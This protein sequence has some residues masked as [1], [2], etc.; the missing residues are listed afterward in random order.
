MH[1]PR[2]KLLAPTLRAGVDILGTA[3]RPM[4]P[5]WKT[6][7]SMHH[8]KHRDFLLQPSTGSRGKDLVRT[9]RDLFTTMKWCTQDET[10]VMIGQ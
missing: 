7:H 3:F 5:L 2:R 4:Q 6:A 1:T 10:L 8:S 9:A